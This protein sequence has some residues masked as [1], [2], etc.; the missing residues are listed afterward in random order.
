MNSLRRTCTF[1]L[2]AAC[3]IGVS[4][5]CSDEDAPPPVEL[6]GEGA[7]A[8]IGLV[9]FQIRVLD[10]NGKELLRTLTGG[11]GDPYGAPAATR[12][13]GPDNIRIIPGWDGYLPEERSWAHG[14]RARVISK[15]DTAASFE[16]D[17]GAG[18]FVIDVTLD[19]AKVK[20]KTTATS[21][22]TAPN[23]TWNKSSLA[24]ALGPDEH[25]FGLGE[26]FASVDHRGMS[27]YAWAEEVGAGKGENVPPDEQNPF[28]NGPSMT[29][30]PVPFFYSTSGYAMHIG[31]TYRTE[32]HFGSERQDAWRIAANT[33]SFE[34][35]IYVHEDP[36]TSLDDFT[37]DTGR[38]YIPAS[39]VFGPRKRVS[40]GDT[41]K[42]EPEWKKIRDTHVPM[43]QL[44]DAVHL[45]PARSELGQEAALLNWTTTSH[46]W[47]FKVIAY[48][49]P[50][51]AMTRE[52]AAGDLAFGKERNLF[53]RTA[54]G[55][56]GETFFISGEPLTL[57]TIDLTNPQGVAWFQDLLR[58]SLA[59]GYDGWMHDFGEYVRRSWVFSDGRKGD[60]VHNLFPVL[61][62]KAAHDLLTKERG[63]DFMF[64]VRSGYTG[65]QQYV[66]AVWSSDP[67]A[68][69]DETQGLP[70]MIRAG[71]NLGM[72]GV[73][74]WGS[75]MSGYK[76]LTNFPNDKDIYLRWAQFAAVSPIMQE[77]NA[78]SNP[79]Q[80]KEKWKLWNDDET[81]RLYS[82]MTRLHTRLSPYFDMLARE[83][84]RSGIPIM[85]HP[86]LYHPREPEAWKVDDAY[87]LGASLWAAPVIARGAT[88]RD[89]WLPPGK[90]VEI[91]DHAAYEGGKHVLLPA[92]LDRLPLLLK[93]GGIVP[94]LDPSIETLAPATEPSVVTL[95]KVKDRLDVLVALSPG[96]DANITLADG[97]TLLARRAAS[98]AAPSALPEVMPET[99]AACEGGCVSTSAEGGVDRLRL[100][101]PLGTDYVVTHGDVTLEAHGP[102]ARFV[103]WDV[104]RFR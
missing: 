96:R 39:W 66:P 85:R 88:T 65:T 25:F 22:T 62:A 4:P 36:L 97:T 58:R 43:T 89:T 10:P 67:E 13:D 50:Y 84:N 17:A 87:Y 86:F 16:L 30:F 8:I 76:C 3:A 44:D 45:L 18:T 61:S 80:D 91:F 34:A 90:W 100:T 1:A 32:T 75:D 11:G 33:T 7:R 23:D 40:I 53:A 28:P 94:L 21:G 70:A 48:N 63:N 81:I 92:P 101:T 82:D 12:D 26:R 59:L 52:S 38:S 29:G 24:F 47:G 51:I 83:A 9:P 49:N 20:L 60:E 79:L 71:V 77:E 56:I 46:A 6:R 72:S 73:P 27:L 74:L 102:T 98:S 37:R 103:R 104:K 42:G 55:A 41:V 93:D 2:A 19:G 5:A 35:T 64:F 31:T 68:T 14:A 99:L 15:T 95:E 78:C 57:A 69:F 54:D